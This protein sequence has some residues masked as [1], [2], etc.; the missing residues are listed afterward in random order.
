MWRR[1]ESMIHVMRFKTKKNFIYDATNKEKTSID[2]QYFSFTPN[3]IFSEGSNM[4]IMHNVVNRQYGRSANI[5][6]PFI[7]IN[8][9]SNQRSYE[10]DQCFSI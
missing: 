3:T 10:N 5:D 4:N 1:F 7:N 8:N 6:I 9:N 2:H